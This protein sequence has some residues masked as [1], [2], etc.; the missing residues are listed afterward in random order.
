MLPN[1]G[2]EVVYKSAAGVRSIELDQLTVDHIWECEPVRGF[3]SYRGQKNY[4][5][6]YWSATNGSLV[7]YESLLELECLRLVDAKTSTIA[8]R[9]QPFRIREWDEHGIRRHHIPD[10]ALIGEHQDVHIINVKP[11]TRLND[12]KTKDALMWANKVITAHGFTHEVW[13]GADRIY[14]R[15]HK[16]LSAYRHSRRLPID[17]AH[18]AHQLVR[19]AATLGEAFTQVASVYGHQARPIVFHLMWRN[20]IQVNLNEPLTDNTPVE[21]IT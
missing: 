6:L 4:P 15:N 10:F 21:V 9:S 13:T 2:V 14:S 16:F 17:A 20:I 18:T 8:I 19:G 1:P 7:A 5:G 11:A 3:A 12:Q